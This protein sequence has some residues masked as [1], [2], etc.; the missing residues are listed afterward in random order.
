VNNAAIILEL[1]IRY[2]TAAQQLAILYNTARAEGR[3]V[4]P[5]ELESLVEKDDISRAQLDAA[6]TKAREREGK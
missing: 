4:T 3:D 2:T 5:E 6:I 1:L